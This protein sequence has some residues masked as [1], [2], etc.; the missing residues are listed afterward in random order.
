MTELQLI[1]ACKRSDSFAQRLLYEQ[2]AEKIFILCL[3]YV[4]NRHDAEELL[5]DCFVK[6]FKHVNQ[7]QYVGDGSLAAWVRK[8]AV[9]E[10]LMSLR[11]KK[12]L[13]ISVDEHS[14]IQQL[15][16]EDDVFQ[17]LNVAV[18]LK[19]I[20]KLPAGYRTVFNL[21]V[22]EDNSHKEI[23]EMLGIS[24]NTS[25]SQLFKARNMLK[26]MLNEN[27]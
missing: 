3:R 16:Q 5:S 7:F 9:N 17:H 11:K 23:A 20:Q 18:I 27:R 14:G 10:C 13:V 26:E 8:I 19:N 24:E 2:F 22:F 25:K 12:Q 15:A 1:E 4:T 21:F 6:A